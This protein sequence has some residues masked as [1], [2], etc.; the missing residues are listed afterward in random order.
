M[1]KLSY[2]TPEGEDF[3]KDMAQLLHLARS[4]VHFDYLTAFAEKMAETFGEQSNW[5]WFKS[6]YT[7][8]PYQGWW[9]GASEVEGLSWW[10]G[11]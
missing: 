10:V 2:N 4:E 7:E 1:G 5:K 6:T 11:A 9:V 8:A 3:F